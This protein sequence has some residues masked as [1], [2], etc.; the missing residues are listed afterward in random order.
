MEIVLAYNSS[1]G[2]VLSAVRAALHTNGFVPDGDEIRNKIRIERFVFPADTIGV[3]DDRARM[4]IVGDEA[5]EED[6]FNND[7]HS[8]TSLEAKSNIEKIGPRPIVVRNSCGEIPPFLF[9]AV[10]PEDERIDACNVVD[11]RMSGGSATDRLLEKLGLR[12][13]RDD[14]I[15]A[16]AL[17]IQPEWS[18]GLL[19]DLAKVGKATTARALRELDPSLSES[20]AAALDAITRKD[21]AAL[22]ECLEA[23]AV[24]ELVAFHLR[25]GL[26]LLHIA[27]CVPGC[28]ALLDLLLEHGFS[29]NERSNAGDTPLYFAAWSEEEMAANLLDRGADPANVSL[30]GNSL[31][32]VAAWLGYDKLTE[33]AIDAGASAFI[34]DKNGGH[35]LIWA[36]Q[37][38]H[39]EIVRKITNRFPAQI[40]VSTGLYGL[41]EN[42]PEF[43]SEAP[44][45]PAF[46]RYRRSRIAKSRDLGRTALMVAVST[47]QTAIIDLLLELGADPNHGNRQGQRPLHY[48]AASASDVTERLLLKLVKAGADVDAIDLDG[49]TPLSN[50][51]LGDRPDLVRHLLAAYANPELK[52][53]EGFTSLHLAS[54]FGKVEIIRLLADKADTEAR[55]SK[56]FT[57]LHLSI[58]FKDVPI[59]AIQALLE[60]EADPD[61]KTRD[62]RRPLSLLLNAGRDNSSKADIARLLIAHRADPWSPNTDGQI[63]VLIAALDEFADFCAPALDKSS[64]LIASSRE[65]SLALVCAS[66]IG[67]IDVVTSLVQR[68]TRINYLAPNGFRALAA[69][70]LNGHINVIQFLLNENALV[71][72]SS[73][74]PTA[75]TCA[76]EKGYDEIVDLLVTN[77]ADPNLPGRGG[78]TPL[79]YAI[80]HGN[81]DT[82]KRL[83]EVGGYLN[84]RSMSGTTPLHIVARENHEGVANL[85]L[86]LKANIEARDDDGDT[87][88]HFAV[89]SEHVEVLHLLLNHGACPDAANNK[90]IRPIHIAAQI[91]SIDAAKLLHEKGA[92]LEQYDEDNDTPLHVAAA[93]ERRD[94]VE[95]LLAEGVALE[96]RNADGDRPIDL[97]SEI[98]VQTIFLDRG[99]EAPRERRQESRRASFLRWNP[100]ESI[101]RQRV[102]EICCEIA[103]Q[104]PASGDADSSAFGDVECATLP[105]YP[106]CYIAAASVF[107]KAPPN[108][109][110]FVISENTRQYTVLDWTNE[111]IYSFNEKVGLALT[112]DDALKIYIKFFFFFV[113]GRMGRFIIVEDV[114]DI[115]WTESASHKIKAA[116][117]NKLLPLSTI[118]D[119]P[120]GMRRLRFTCIFRNALFRSDV[121]M[122]LQSMEHHWPEDD[123]PSQFTIGQSVLRNEELL[124]E[125]LPIVVP[126][127]PGR[128]G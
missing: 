41:G 36:S 96:P 63:A 18:V 95:W 101:Q 23:D 26:S 32:A 73:G 124:E 94:F 42:D 4:V 75:L 66:A 123:D 82:A 104:R 128:F 33:R 12:V 16:E 106:D 74:V 112:S 59:E 17:L 88:L 19:Y 67:R 79:F 43:S 84:V 103:I 49:V 92:S 61:S 72:P 37:A 5:L 13:P 122:A 111:P 48:L 52:N 100:A 117:E 77:G 2:R 110:F 40:D 125:D 20:A 21:V 15:M 69:A 121:Y 78:W 25:G 127:A 3:R 109:I 90:L 64:S 118:D 87:P 68:G 114:A 31:L 46:V 85:L 9:P 76:A 29:P 98:A 97:T 38:G 119:A 28:S 8:A 99:V 65:A 91:G 102:E 58:F 71:N 10:V 56:G 107:G 44:N 86:D 89:M 60:N 27:A 53:A 62:G 45:V 30:E 24:K 120:E 7:W 57:P 55:D 6:P 105:F 81:S 51:V 70:S 50:A 14:I 1:E 115:D 93:N 83:L 54:S 11:F 80:A 113:R 22:R 34:T 126:G 39:A 116:V 47:G 108:Q 35:P